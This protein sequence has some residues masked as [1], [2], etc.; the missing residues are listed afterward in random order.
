MRKNKCKESARVKLAT[1]FLLLV[2][3]CGCGSYLLQGSEFSQRL[4]SDSGVT[5]AAVI[6]EEAT[7][8]QPPVPGES[9]A[10]MAILPKVKEILYDIGLDGIIFVC[11]VILLAVIFSGVRYYRRAVQTKHLVLSGRQMPPSAPITPVS[12]AVP[13]QRLTPASGWDAQLQAVDAQLARL[14]ERRRVRV[15]TELPRTHGIPRDTIE[16]NPEIHREKAQKIS[17]FLAQGIKKPYQFLSKPLHHPEKSEAQKRAEEEYQQILRL[18]WEIDH[19]SDLSSQ[20]KIE[21]EQELKEL[22]R[23]FKVRT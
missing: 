22:E 19:Y 16:S 14:D 17:L 8:K 9:L 3:V 10:R 5:G 21:L 2:V 6:E 4:F 13:S 7:F 15:I 12:Q 1:Y 11:S 23:R 18:H 20:Q